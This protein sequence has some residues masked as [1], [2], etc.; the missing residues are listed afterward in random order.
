M[1]QRINTFICRAKI[2]WPGVQTANTSPWKASYR[3]CRFSFCTWRRRISSQAFF[4]LMDS[5]YTCGEGRWTDTLQRLHSISYH[6]PYDSA[7]IAL[8]L[9][10]QRPQI[11]AGISIS[12]DHHTSRKKLSVVVVVK[13]VE[14]ELNLSQNSGKENMCV[15][16]G[17]WGS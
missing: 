14:P 15:V 6:L 4:V 13:C 16:V 9:L 7:I 12:Y 1:W 17:G 8:L 5:F 3:A 10:S 11:Q 2:R